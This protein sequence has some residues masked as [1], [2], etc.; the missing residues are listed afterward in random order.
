MA[1]QAQLP[2]A[3]SKRIPCPVCHHIVL[4]LPGSSEVKALENHLEHEH[5]YTSREAANEA[6]SAK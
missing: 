1:P 5:W 2:D 3:K 4:A 6:A